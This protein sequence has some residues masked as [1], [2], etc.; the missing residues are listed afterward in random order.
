MQRLKGE[1]RRWNTTACEYIV[2]YIV[3]FAFWSVPDELTAILDKLFVRCRPV[4][5]LGRVVDN[6]W[7]DLHDIH[8]QAVLD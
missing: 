4:K 1:Q 7:V 8:K 3:I 6:S 5:V 2:D